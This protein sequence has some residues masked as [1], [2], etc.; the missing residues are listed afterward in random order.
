MRDVASV[1]SR[2]SIDASTGAWPGPPRPEVAARRGLVVLLFSLTALF[3]LLV[4]AY[5]FRMRFGDW[6][7]LSTPGVLW[8]S[9]GLLV[10]CSIAFEWSRQSLAQGHQ[11]T[12]RTALLAAGALAAAF[13]LAQWW[14]WREMQALGFYLYTNPAHSFFYLVT[15]MHAIHVVAGL[16]GW[17]VSLRHLRRGDRPQAAVTI[18]GIYWHFLLVVWLGLY[19]VLLL[20]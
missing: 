8:L 13:L 9:T 10:A 12:G 6:V 3:G 7:A 14:A 4:S 19:T 5:L 17:L 20:T 2:G 15:A 11:S 18:C 1:R 16:G